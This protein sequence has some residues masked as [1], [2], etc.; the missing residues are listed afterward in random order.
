M[1]KGG[2]VPGCHTETVEKREGNWGGGGGGA[3]LRPISQANTAN[4]KHKPQSRAHG[5]LVYV[6]VGTLL[7]TREH[8][9]SLLLTPLNCI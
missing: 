5:I 3:A 7:T 9:H 6:H 1:Q 2:Q 4:A 8:W